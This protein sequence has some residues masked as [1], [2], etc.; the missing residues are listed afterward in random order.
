MLR[1][2]FA[3]FS[4]FFIKLMN[5]YVKSQAKLYS[6]QINHALIT[7]FPNFVFSVYIF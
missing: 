5:I 1:F 6:T 4:K 2:I 7:I 3:Y